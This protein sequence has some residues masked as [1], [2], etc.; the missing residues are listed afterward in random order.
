MNIELFFLIMHTH[1]LEI[2][3]YLP[4]D[5]VG[6]IA[7]WQRC[8]LLSPANNPR[9][10]IARKLRVNPDLFFVG[11]LKEALV[12]TCMAGYEGHRG[13]INYLAVE[14]DYRQQGLASQIMTQAEDALKALGC[15]KINLQVRSTNTTVIAFYESLGFS[16]DPVTSM[17]KRLMLDP[18]Y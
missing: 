9:E 12:A 17:G 3:P 13:W 1:T 7:L 18:P 2:R 14:P 8:N 16:I 10:D 11:L 4:H 5:E 6:V 15:P